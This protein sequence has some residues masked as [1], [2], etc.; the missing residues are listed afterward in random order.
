LLFTG[1]IFSSTRPIEK[2]QHFN[3]TVLLPFTLVQRSIYHHFFITD[4]DAAISAKC[5]KFFSGKT[6][7]I[8]FCGIVAFLLR[9][10]PVQLFQE[11][12]F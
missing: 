6:I 7:W 5:T 9:Q 11:Y 1:F 8:L 3:A 10:V 12:W 4:D 2:V